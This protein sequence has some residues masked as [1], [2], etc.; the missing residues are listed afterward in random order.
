MQVPASSGLASSAESGYSLPPLPTLA[1]EG[2]TL[3]HAAVTHHP[4]PQEAPSAF[5]GMVIPVRD[6]SGAVRDWKLASENPPDTRAAFAR[7]HAG[8][9][10]EAVIG[11][12][13]TARGLMT[14]A[15]G[16][17]DL[18]ELG[19]LQLPPA[20]IS[21]RHARKLAWQLHMAA[22]E[23]DKLHAFGIGVSAS[24]NG[25]LARGFVANEGPLM[26]LAEGGA[27]VAA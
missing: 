23:A 22:E 25:G 19:I 26:L 17:I 4:L 14:W 10:T 8:F 11:D 7:W 3:I 5:E 2:P 21:A 27:W 6:R 12:V 15:R 13:A 18:S 20:R 9:V 16:R 1:G 24:H